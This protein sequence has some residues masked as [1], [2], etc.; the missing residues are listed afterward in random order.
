MV[1]FAHMILVDSDR[2]TAMTLGRSSIVTETK[3]EPLS[4][5]PLDLILR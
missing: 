1:F 3:P 5:H 4:T 2:G